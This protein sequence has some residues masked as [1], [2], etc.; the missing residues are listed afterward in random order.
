MGVDIDHVDALNALKRRALV[1]TL[2][3][4]GAEFTCASDKSALEEF[5]FALAEDIGSIAKEI[6]AAMKEKNA[7]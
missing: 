3:I 1:L 6:H 7:D 2:A 5:A 4:E